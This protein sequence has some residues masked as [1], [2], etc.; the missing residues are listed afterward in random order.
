MAGFGG[1]VQQFAH[2]TAGTAVAG[3]VGSTA[4]P[5][6]QFHLDLGSL[7]LGNPVEERVLVAWRQILDPS[8][9]L[10]GVVLRLGPGRARLGC[11]GEQVGVEA[12]EVGQGALWGGEDSQAGGDRW[13]AFVFF[14]VA[15]GVLVA[16]PGA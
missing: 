10:A 13:F 5:A 12:E 4:E 1:A 16:F 2:R 9:Q 3:G 14:V 11:D 15:E 7:A 6:P 8:G